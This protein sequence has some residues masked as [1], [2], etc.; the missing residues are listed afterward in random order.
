M[1]LYKELNLEPVQSEPDVWVSRI[2]ILERITPSPVVIR[3]ISL[4]RGL[5]IVWAEEPENDDPTA[6][7]TGHSAG[8]T[9]FCRLLRYVLG[10]R[11][12]GTRAVM[13]L[14]R[15][16]FPDGYIAA[17]LQVRGRKWAVRRP[18]GS[19][20]MSFIKG[21][22][23]IEELFEQRGASVTQESYP[24]EIGLESLLD[25]LETGGIVQTGET[26]QWAHILA[27]C[28]RDQEARFQNIH[29]WRS[30]RS[31]AETP[32]F[33]F[34]KAGPLFV[35]RAALGLFLPDELK[36]EERLAELLRDKD[37]LNKEIEDK[38]REP[39]FRVKLYGQ[40]LRQALKTIL[41]DEP[42]IDSRLFQ[43]DELFPE[44]L[45]GLTVKAREKTEKSI[46]NDEQ[47]LL[48]LQAQIDELGAE[49][50]R[51]ER[52]LAEMETFFDLNGAASR[53]LS[54]ELSKSDERRNKFNE[55]KHKLCPFGDI[56]VRDCQYVQDR[57]RII[58]ISDIQDTH[59]I[60][61]EE[62]RRAVA[63]QKI[64]TEKIN[65]RKE[66]NQIKEERQ[67]SL[68]RRGALMARIRD[69]QELIRTVERSH[70]ELIVWKQR[71]DGLGS[72]EELDQLR[73]KL[74]STE[75]EIARFEQD[76]ATLLQQHN[77]NR[78]RL[79]SIFSGAVRSVLSSD[80]Y[81]GRVSLANRELA[82]HIT[83]GPAMSGEAVETLSVLLADVAALIYNTVSD[84]A[85][86]PGFLL[87]DSPREADLGIRIYRS[88]LR[89]AASLQE[90]FE[91][92]ERCPFQYF[93]TTT[94]A[95]PEDL[96]DKYMK[97]RLNASNANGLLLRRNIAA[98]AESS[99]ERKLF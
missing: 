71:L 45:R 96:R 21:E 18:F 61:Q 23:S 92:A 9:I 4:S 59:A 64:E 43:S 2:M 50:G 49:L 53:E 76:L 51:Q 33:R 55:Y 22:A 70:D 73:R 1:D 88:F 44:D 81:D 19:G 12:F 27:W 67:N 86:L 68:E 28:T 95:P 48:N 60:E 56:Y 7:I 17:E 36:G 25:E 85:H 89:F 97:L 78:R 42:D 62:A 66:I 80:R 20:R 90:H 6:A 98:E 69:Q 58:H 37:R 30:P 16:A 79:G 74:D 83:Q 57:Q 34:P 41:P 84:K 31:E 46:E 5:N 77:E 75:K 91:G 14:I 72:Y 3:D 47:E 8:K 87:H 93:I 63:R 39:Q 26:I 54:A 99:I 35:M 40:Q 52:E 24:Q 13:E 82:F 94:T 11:T 32:S 29:D 65:L 15:K 38:R 10:E